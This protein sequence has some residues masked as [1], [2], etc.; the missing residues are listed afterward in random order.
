MFL[1]ERKINS[2]KTEE[3]TQIFI[4]DLMAV[5]ENSKY[6]YQL[7]LNV[8]NSKECE[9]KKVKTNLGLKDNLAPLQ[10]TIKIPVYF[11][12]ALID[13]KLEMGAISLWNGAIDFYREDIYSFS[14]EEREFWRAFRRLPYHG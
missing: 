4:N 13:K 6:S 5:F 8:I 7:T 11:L 9:L 1:L 10:L 2:K 3:L 12:C 14:V